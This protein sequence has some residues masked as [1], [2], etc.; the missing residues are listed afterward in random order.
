MS[1][2]RLA[3]LLFLAVPSVSIARA[4]GGLELPSLDKERVPAAGRNQVIATIPNFGR[5][6]IVVTSEEG[7]AVQLVDRMAGPGSFHGVPGDVD[8]RIDAFLERGEYKI[9]TRGHPA[10][11][12]KAK[13]AIKRFEEKGEEHPTRLIEH[14]PVEATLHDLEQRSYWIHLPR[15]HTVILEAAGRSLADLRL[16]RDGRWLVDAQPIIEEVYARPG[17]PIGVCRLSAKLP[18]GLYLLT[19]YGGPARDW[20]EDE[21]ASAGHALHLRYGIPPLSSVGRSK[22]TLS[23]FGLDR[24]HLPSESRQVQLEVSEPTDVELSLVPFDKSSPFRP[25]SRRSSIHKSSIMP[26]AEIMGPTSETGLIVTVAGEAGQPY[27]LSHFPRYDDE[28]GFLAPGRAGSA[29]EWASYWVSTVHSG[30]A[31]DNTDATAVL[32][33]DHGRGRFLAGFQTEKVEVQAVDVGPDLPWVRQFDL[34]GTTTVHINVTSAGSYRFDADPAARFRIEPLMVRRPARYVI[35]DTRPSGNE[36]SL[37]EGMHVLTIEPEKKGALKASLSSASSRPSQS[38]IWN[39]LFKARP[40]YLDHLDAE[41][42][43]PAAQWKDVRLRPGA[44]YGL[45]LASR[46]GIHTGVVVRRLPID[47]VDPLPVVQRADETLTI[48]VRVS[49]PGVL[50][51][52]TDKGSLMHFSVND[53]SP[54]SE[55][56]LEPGDYQVRIENRA[57]RKVRYSLALKPEH[58]SS[59]I[60]L[61]RLCDAL[62]DERPVFPALE[63]NRDHY[64]DIPREGEASY[65]IRIDGPGLYRLESTGLLDTEASVRTRTNPSLQRR[66]DGG[67][68]RNFLMQLY[69]REGEYQATTRVR[70][71]SAGRL[72]LRL[73]P[74]RLVEGGVLRDGLPARENLLAGEGLLYRFEV[75]KEGTYRLESLG[76]GGPFA[77]RLEDENGWPLIRPGVMG[78][79]ELDLAPGLYRLIV[80]PSD[81][82]GRCVTRVSRSVSSPSFSGRGP[83]RLPL[84]E[85]VTH[86]W[87]EP[88][89]GAARK[90]DVW[91]FDLP[92]PAEVEIELGA[93]M[94]GELFFGDQKLAD[95]LPGRGWS[96]SLSA[97]SHRLELSSVRPNDRLNYGLTVRPRQLLD[98]LTRE[99]RA[100]T[101]I[102]V[103]VGEP[104]LVSLSAHGRADVRARLFDASG[105]L[106]AENDDRPGD[107]SFLI[108]TYLDAG[109][110][111]LSV[112][113]VGSS[114]AATSITMDVVDKAYGDSLRTPVSRDLRPGDEMIV[115]PLEIDSPGLLILSA[116]SRETIGMAIDAREGEDEPWVPLASRLGR[117]VLLEIPLP[118]S[119]SAPRVAPLDDV[120]LGSGDDPSRGRT[121][122]PDDFEQA[123]SSPVGQSIS[124]WRYRLRIWSVDRTGNEVELRALTVMPRTVTE[125]S[126]AGTA[127][128]EL[129]EGIKPALAV[130]RVE[131]ERPGALKIRD[132]EVLETLRFSDQIHV[133]ARPSPDG[134]LLRKGSGAAWLVRDLEDGASRRDARVTLERVEVPLEEQLV[135]RIPARE[136]ASVN[137]DPE[138]PRRWIFGR[139]EVSHGPVVVVASSREGQP[140]IEIVDGEGEPER[141]GDLSVVGLGPR[142]AVG[143]SL[144]GERRVARYWNAKRAHSHRD[145]DIRTSVVRNASAEPESVQL[146]MHTGVVAR[147]QSRSFDLPPGEKTLHLIID[148]AT[149]AVLSDGE[150]VRSV[151]GGTG[152][153]I[154]EVLKSSA[155]NLTIMPVRADRGGG[156][157]FELLPAIAKERYLVGPERPFERVERTK[158]LIR[159]EISGSQE[160]L[161]HR[162]T[163]RARGAIDE[164][165]FLGSDGILHRGDS[166]VPASGGTLLL[167]HRAGPLFV[168]LDGHGDDQ[169]GLIAVDEKVAPLRSVFL[170]SVVELSGRMQ[171]L[172]VESLKEEPTILHLRGFEPMVVSISGPGLHRRVDIHHEGIAEDLILPRGAAEVL[173]RAISGRTL[174]GTLSLSSTE[175][176]KASEGLGP[177]VML[178]PMKARAFS[179]DV[180]RAGPVGIG[181]WSQADRVECWLLDEHGE[182]V[183]EAVGGSV[184][185]M[186]QLDTGRYYLFIRSD[187]EAPALWARPALAGIRPPDAGPPKEVLRRYLGRA[188]N[189]E[190]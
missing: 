52:R 12:G 17:E 138:A 66:G 84:D 127:R 22:R 44:R 31:I 96:G 149:L 181:A 174:G 42:S 65:S 183:S 14:R 165:L 61:P 19:A 159:L 5:F 129:V 120:L 141:P 30:H 59:D 62:L 10:A 20:A 41:A 56:R 21:D 137:I 125:S 78:D 76:L 124:D 95:V 153:A 3:L 100:P 144:A 119:G 24:F 139:R 126:L 70:G 171:R 135:L 8:G 184:V 25:G 99:I 142:V 123:P 157:S 166:P 67:S 155:S 47:P 101:S 89:E 147:G 73:S 176:L 172:R 16:W 92:G 94:E 151:H 91:L 105:R 18:A 130:V 146:G 112:E 13:V 33:R 132:R 27:T 109:Q 107:W 103:S 140:A 160:P 1:P 43:L 74:A 46:P 179:F 186:P 7:T 72:G 190:I 169:L 175:L 2:L 82:G 131:G 111:E 133:P 115:H 77:V 68:G 75:E 182:P 143:V 4:S 104:G 97:G 45:H 168:W 117:R 98:G 114:S 167:Y 173:V 50:R 64:L 34:Q 128:M 102:P 156:Y 32:I 35:P 49:E 152:Q 110:Y 170:P 161:R 71:R 136:I 6:A 87:R 15:E 118:E 158:G 37:D 106:V 57:D 48:P 189:D 28:E 148:E 53:D 63:L 36:W 11:R 69:L 83:H 29:R 108:S 79:L 178:G 162:R 39:L 55:A 145:L 187:A 26:V 164:A 51:A 93:R 163:V 150:A 9:V 88:S 188:E 60:P 86:Q 154:S 185:A 40:D 180:E 58:L 122:S 134:A 113:P 116:K 23:P 80:L 54:K 177:K 81:M 85:S 121:P 38:W 90:P